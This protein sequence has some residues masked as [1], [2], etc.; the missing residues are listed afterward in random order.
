MLNRYGVQMLNSLGAHLLSR[1]GDRLLNRLGVHLLN[2]LGVHLF[3]RFVV[4]L[5]SRLGVHLFVMISSFDLLL[6]RLVIID[7]FC[8]QLYFLHLWFCTFIF[9][10]VFVR[11]KIS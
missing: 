10:N 5:L 6:G 8:F 3:N 11:D 2:R 1:H 7:L 9:L 4:H